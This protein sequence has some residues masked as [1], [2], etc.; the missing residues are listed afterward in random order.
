MNGCGP[1]KRN[2]PLRLL[3][4]AAVVAAAAAAA[5]VFRRC[6]SPPR[7][8]PAATALAP[9]TPSPFLNTR[10]GVAYVGD[11]RCAGCHPDVCD[12]YQQHPMALSL[13][14]AG[15]AP[16]LE[17]YDPKANDPFQSGPFHFQ[18]VRDGPRLIHKEWCQD[19]R[20]KIVAERQ[21]EI[22][23]EVGAGSQGRSYFYE[24]DGFLFESPITWYSQP[25]RWQLSPG[26]ADHLVHFSRRIRRTMSILPQPRGASGG[27]IHQPLP[28]TAVWTAGY[29]LRALPRPRGTAR[30]RAPAG[31]RAE[32]CGP[33]HCQSAPPAGG[34]AGCGV[35]AMPSAR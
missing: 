29:R 31:R 6:A 20:G 12:A 18:V 16:P 3:V 7:P 32:R 34:L 14:R 35:R 23:Y 11:E 9:L 10:P 26:Y 8:R 27:A 19:A 21:E 24:R 33:D 25:S 15:D 4:G 22:A 1:A 2:R 30:R 5:F 28:A 17:Q 13:F